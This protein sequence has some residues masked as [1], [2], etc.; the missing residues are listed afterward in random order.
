[1]LTSDVV[2]GYML[3]AKLIMPVSL[4]TSIRHFSF[5]MSL[6]ETRAAYRM[7]FCSHS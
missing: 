3:G 2:N 6:V 1:V 7:F 5:L 4:A